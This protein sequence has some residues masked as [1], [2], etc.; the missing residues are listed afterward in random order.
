MGSAAV[1]CVPSLCG[2]C[3]SA[4]SGLHL[5]DDGHTAAVLRRIRSLGTAGCSAAGRAPDGWRSLT[6]TLT[7]APAFRPTGRSPIGSGTVIV[8]QRGTQRR[9]A[10]VQQQPLVA[11]GHLKDLANLL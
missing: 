2:P 1:G 6:A 9:P 5:V 11:G 10:A 8:L 4:C 7:A 3:P